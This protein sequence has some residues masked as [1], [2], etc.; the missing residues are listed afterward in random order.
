[1]LK[2]R[3]LHDLS[4]ET[5]G[6]YFNYTSYLFNH[7]IH[8]ML[9]THRPYKYRSGIATGTVST[10]CIEWQSIGTSSNNKE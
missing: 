9:L 2:I 10:K 1:M 3:I 8:K 7:P 6:D 5:K 4:M